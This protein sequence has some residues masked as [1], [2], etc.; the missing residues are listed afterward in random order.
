MK[1]KF[2]FVAEI[3]HKISSHKQLVSNFASLSVLQ[4]LNY[5]FPLITFPYLVRIL[6]TEKFGLLMFAQAFITYFSVI[7]EYGFNLSAT[8]DISIHRDNHNKTTEIFSSV[9]LLRT[10][11]MLFSFLLLCICIFS[12]E[13]FSQDKKIYL[14]TFGIII[15]QV[16]FPIW[17]FQG[18]EKMKYITYLN[19]FTKS[20]FTI[21]IFIFIK[22]QSDYYLVPVIISI[23]SIFSGIWALFLIKKEFNIS[24]KFQKFN[25]LKH[26]LKKSH[27]LFISNIALSVYSASTTVILGLVTNNAV[28]GYYAAAGKIIHAFNNLI[29]PIT[30][31]LYPFISSKVANSKTEGLLFIRKLVKYIGLFTFALSIFIFFGADFLVNLLLGTQYHNSV[32]ALKILSALPFITGLN[33][34][35]G[36]QTMIT[37]GKE[38]AFSNILITACSLNFALSFVLASL[39]K[40]IGSAISI[41]IV[42]CFITFTMLIYLQKNNLKL[43]GKI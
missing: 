41:V 40:H 9:M 2:N 43:I 6:G 34:I 1:S 35:F 11:L 3:K 26:H 32:V 19:L 8:K 13:K 12:F 29:T 16:L 42:E 5:I 15:G 38:K 24:F 37:F 36:I 28:V 25:T 18:M 39:Y 4:G 22:Q 33:N 23:G 20:V 27:F 31:V 10:I 17:F 7:T 30:Q 14:L 21:A